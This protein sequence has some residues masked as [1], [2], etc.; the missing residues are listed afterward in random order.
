M[1]IDFEQ[2]FNQLPAL[3]VLVIGNEP[4]YTVVAV[5]DEYLKSVNLKRG[6][7]MGKPLFEP[8][9]KDPT[10]GESGK[11]FR[12]LSE[13]VRTK[14]KL[15]PEFLRYDITIDGVAHTKY[16]CSTNVPIMDKAGNLLYIIH[17]PVEVTTLIE[18]G[19]KIQ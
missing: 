13:V 7:M 4:D 18:K 17:S 10:K 8:F 12:T 15:S 14:K 1:K 3:Y 16:W 9:T 19:L 2:I 5:S 11:L 6:D